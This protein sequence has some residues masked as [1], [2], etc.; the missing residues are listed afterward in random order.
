MSSVN[1]SYELGSSL[2]GEAFFKSKLSR[3]SIL[4]GEE[5]FGRRILLT[6]NLPM[7]NFP[8]VELTSKEF[9][10][11]NLPVKNLPRT[12]TARCSF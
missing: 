7:K 12:F 1:Q 6:K 11:K 10:V 8:S 4:K 9:A 2:I 5:F 3:Q